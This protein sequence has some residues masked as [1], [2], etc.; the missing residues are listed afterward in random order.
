MHLGEASVSRHL[1]GG[2]WEEASEGRHLGGLWEK[3]WEGSGRALGRALGALAALEAP[4]VS[5][6]VYLHKVAPVCSR[7]QKFLFLFTVRSVFEGTTREVRSRAAFEDRR[8]EAG[9]GEPTESTPPGPYKLKLF[10]EQRH[11]K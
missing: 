5:G 8:L 11:R 10:R 2:I 7:L 9:V 3:L 6:M 4:G 1:G